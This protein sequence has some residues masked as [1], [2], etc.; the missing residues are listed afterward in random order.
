MRASDGA[1]TGDS[2]G[3]RAGC[4]K[5]AELLNKMQYAQYVQWFPGAGG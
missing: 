1:L 5:N 3:S 2:G 4:L